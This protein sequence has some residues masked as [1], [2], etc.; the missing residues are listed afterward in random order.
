M[1]SSNYRFIALPPKDL[2]D[3]RER[4]ASQIPVEAKPSLY[5]YD[6]PAL[7]EEVRNAV[8]LEMADSMNKWAGA[9][10]RAITRFERPPH[11]PKFFQLKKGGTTIWTNKGHT[12]LM[13]PLFKGE[14]KISVRARDSDTSHSIFWTCENA[15]QLD[16]ETGVRPLEEDLVFHYNNFLFTEATQGIDDRIKMEESI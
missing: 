15:L 1:E 4:L 7:V 13:V 12:G 5:V 9:K 14:V 8:V 6:L 16:E 2:Q 10:H 11:T 3:V